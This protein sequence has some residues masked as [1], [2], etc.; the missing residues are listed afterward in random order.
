MENLT[1]YAKNIS[2]SLYEQLKQA[3]ETG[4]WLDGNKLSVQQKE[5]S[6]QLVMAYQSQFNDDPEHMSIAKGGEIHMKK[7]SVLKAQF[8]DKSHSDTHRIDL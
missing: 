3:V 5:H 2:P 6:L 8:S 1:D 4:K 7:K